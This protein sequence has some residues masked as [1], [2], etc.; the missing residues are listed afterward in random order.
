M[1]NSN[2]NIAIDE[3][4]I[5]M[6]YIFL[7][8]RYTFSPFFDS[9]KSSDLPFIGSFEREPRETLADG[10]RKCYSSISRAMR[11]QTWI[12]SQLQR[13]HDD[14]SVHVN[15]T[16]LSIPI[17]IRVLT[18]AGIWEMRC[19]N[20]SRGE[21]CTRRRVMAGCHNTRKPLL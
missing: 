15:L 10:R 16:D 7:S 9:S 21:R 1:Q 2:T 5:N 19:I 20:E 18:H 14:D 11:F 4:Q 6:S 8:M 12:Y 17:L 3:C 13:E